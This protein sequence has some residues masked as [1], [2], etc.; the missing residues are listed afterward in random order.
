MGFFDV[1]S[2]FALHLRSVSGGA[3]PDPEA[4]AQRADQQSLS[5]LVQLPSEIKELI[6]QELWRDEGLAQH[7]ILRR[8]RVVGMTC[9]TD[10]AAP[11]ELQG[12]CEATGSK[13]IRDPVLMKRFQ[14]S[15]GVHWK[16]EELYQSGVQKEGNQW[17]PFLPMLYVEAR[18]SIYKNITFCMHDLDT[19]HSHLVSR[20]AL[21][22][23]NIQHLQLTIHLPLPRSTRGGAS[24]SE[25]ATMSRW[26]QCCEALDRAEN[27][28]SVY[29]RLD[30]PVR[31]RFYSITEGD[32]NPYVFGK[33]LASKLTVDVP[34]NPDRPEAWSEVT[35]IEPRFNIHPRGWPVYSLSHNINNVKRI[36]KLSDWEEP[37]APRGPP[38]R[39]QQYVH[40]GQG[41]ISSLLTRHKRRPA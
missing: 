21:I 31:R 24:Y 23:N 36:S 16:C 17:T 5:P 15:W 8:G 38:E 37:G 40:P 19:T 35:N 22:L 13:I 29:V 20:P 30:A 33:R 32:M 11:D 14:S 10:I 12:M 6:F 3:R 18:T 4:I 2:K 9:V 25:R 34:L 7:L 26:R 27:L 1:K 41:L 39:G 28:V